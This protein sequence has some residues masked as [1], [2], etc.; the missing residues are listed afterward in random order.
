MRD[1]GS[2]YFIVLNYMRTHG[3]GRI[4]EISVGVG[5]SKSIVSYYLTCLCNDGAIS[6]EIGDLWVFLG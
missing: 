3:S 5:F 4:A 6:H 2:K 1:E